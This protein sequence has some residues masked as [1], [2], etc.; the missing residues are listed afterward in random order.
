MTDQ[1][2]R[3]ESPTPRPQPKFRKDYRPPD[4]LIDRVDLRFEL[5]EELT[6]VFARIELHARDGREDS[7]L[8]LHG[9]ALTLK[10]VAVDERELSPE[11]YEVD[12][13]QLT[14]RSLP[15]RC[16]L[17][18]EVEIKPQDN[19]EL[20]GLYKSSG[21]FCTQC[22]AE[23][24][25]RITYFLDRPDVMARY[26]TTIVADPKRYP[27]LLSNGNRVRGNRLAD[28]RVWV[29]WDDPFP[30]PSYLFA[31]VAGDLR[32][33]RGSF[34][35]C[36]GREVALEIYVEPQNIDR[37]EHAL[38]SLQKS[39][40]WDE[41]EFGREYDLDIYMIVAVGDFNMGAMENKGLNVFNSK[42]VLA[43]PETAT[44]EDYVAIEGVIAH[45]YFHNWTGNRV[46]CRDWFQLTLKEGLTV[47]RDQ[48]FTADMISAPVKRIVD[49]LRL[50][51]AQ[52]PEDAGPMSHPIR[53]EQYIEMNNFYTATVYEKGAEVVRMYET[54]L[55]RGGFRKGMDLY[56]DRHDG[57]AVTCDDFRHAMADANEVSL[58]QFERWYL[59][60]GT[61]RLTATGVHDLA[62]RTYALTL[63][64]RAPVGVDPAEYKPLHIPVAAGLVS[65]DGADIPLALA[66]ESLANAPT[67]RVLEL[68]ERSQTFVFQGVDSPPAPSLLRGFSAPVLLECARSRDQ[69]AF[70][71]AHDSD[72][73]NRWE[74][75]QV[76]ATELLL[77]L[78]RAVASGAEL[79]VDPLFIHAYEMILADPTLDDAFKSL[80]LNLPDER[81]LAQSMDVIDVDALHAAREHVAGAL[82][83]A[84]RGPLTQAYAAGR[85]AGPYR[86]DKESIGRRRLQNVALAYLTRL[87]EPET[88][89]LAVTQLDQ[90]DNMTDA[91]A[92]LMCLADIP[93]PE[94]AA[95]FAS[96]YE[97][98][99]HDP[100][101]LDKWFSIQALSSLPS[102]TDEV[103]ALARH[104]DFTLKNPNRVRALIG[105]YSMRNQVRFHDADGR[106]YTLLADAV[107]ELDR[108]NP[109]VASR[110][111]SGFN[112]W[113]RFDE[114]RRARMQAE[115]ER[116]LA[117]AQAEEHPLSRDVYEIVSRALA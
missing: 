29:T 76:L 113:R 85:A 67:T 12:D 30:K 1:A 27:V 28:G 101:V 36:S 58:E 23:G 16:V 68:R 103:I 70:L 100:L 93:G 41:Q 25:R 42:Y 48:R 82:A 4:H 31:L 72:P 13:E 39:M 109:Q 59:Q 43:A 2:P 50:R 80:A 71:T 117:R 88:T 64:Q 33:H 5:G 61:P 40:A 7:P 108:M 84:L 77:E 18:T 37:C 54:L 19:L 89:A 87:R 79:T 10:R 24:F 53:P 22:E 99:K 35:T 75:G 115:L 46:T 95:A 74:A 98:W 45:E 69:L 60:R 26:T 47:Y 34:T 78:T 81:V 62:A 111:V 83:R 91:E 102:A 110:I 20:S 56:F 14:I 105:A 3:G 106:G 17:E 15:A 94:R 8:K 65:P 32:C 114:G 57:Q 107:L 9:E 38:R 90:A 21:N 49:V 44:D 51:L 96:F 112:Q 86:N 6:R 63:E 73:F 52:F 92:A 55:G 97:R 11:E 66:G 104:P 116:I